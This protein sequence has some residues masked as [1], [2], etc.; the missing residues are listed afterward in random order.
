MGTTPIYGTI[1][2]TSSTG[3]T[4][5]SSTAKSADQLQLDFLKLLTTQLQYQ[6][7]MSPTDNTQFTSQMA[8]FSSL[9]AQNRSNTLLQKLLDAQGSG[10]M[11]QAVSYMGKWVIS[12]GN[13]TTVNDG[14]AAVRFQ[15]PQ[16][17]NVNIRI[18]DQ[19]GQMVKNV[20]ALNVAAGE[21]NL[22]VDGIAA[23]N[24][25]YRFAVT[26]LESDG[27]QTALSTLQ[28]QQ[29][30]GVVNAGTAGVM[31]QLGNQLI[32]LTDVTRV[33]LNNTPG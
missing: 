1:P 15:M 29:V 31:L 10:G 4:S 32:A 17:G 7:P 22:A 30:T 18:Y 2:T 14:A 16:A 24:G 21:Q 8:Q 5:G 13:Q 11:N 3:S 6:D 28:S 19:S 20:N 26:L 12:A 27:G 23:D 33:E 9:D 25:A